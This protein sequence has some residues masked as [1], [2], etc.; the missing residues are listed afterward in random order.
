MVGKPELKKPAVHRPVILKWRKNSVTYLSSD[1]ATALILSSTNL[2]K[3]LLT[4]QRIPIFPIQVCIYTAFIHI[5]DLFQWYIFDFFLICRF[6]CIQMP[7]PFPIGMRPGG[8]Q[9]MPSVC[10]DRSFG[11]FCAD[12]SFPNSPFLSAAF[13][14]FVSLI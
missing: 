5:G 6:H 4:P 14:I 8:P 2:S 3:H 10:P 12:L 1:N 9:H 13:P 7:W 11:S